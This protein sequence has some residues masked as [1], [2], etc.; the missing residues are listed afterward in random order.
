M[1]LLLERDQVVVWDEEGN[2]IALHPTHRGD[3]VP[4]TNLWRSQR[5][6]VLNELRE[7]LM[8]FRSGKIIGD[9]SFDATLQKAIT[10]YAQ[11]LRRGQLSS[12]TREE[13]I[14]ELLG[15]A[16][17]L[18]DPARLA[19]ALGV[20]ESEVRAAAA[21]RHEPTPPASSAKRTRRSTV[22]LVSDIVG[23]V[24]S[25]E[26]DVS[27]R[28]DDVS[29]ASGD[30]SLPPEEVSPTLVIKTGADIRRER[31]AR[32]LTQVQ[33]AES[34]GLGETTMVLTEKGRRPIPPWRLREFERW[35]REHPVATGAA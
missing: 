16:D 11:Q 22:K 23:D 14:G 25:P 21:R 6:T 18:F 28:S 34:V 8:Q 20:D 4:G 30:V 12:A 5:Q 24:S 31:L 27:L 3:Y 26:E 19:P 10:L 33:L 7:Q 1:N 35:F 13:A 15:L 2:V 17:V 9:Q 29:F 32:G